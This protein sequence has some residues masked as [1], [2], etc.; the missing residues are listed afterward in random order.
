[1]TDTPTKQAEKGIWLIYDYECPLCDMYCRA[2]RIKKDIGNLTLVD[3]RQP[4]S[5]M[6]EITKLGWD[7]DN[8]MVLKVDDSLY[9]G[10]EAIHILTLLSTRTG[11]F[12]KINYFVF[13][14]HLMSKVLYPFFRSI[15][16]IVLF[17]LMGR[18]KISNL[19]KK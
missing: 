2:I 9:Y 14:S 6:D 10:S 5:V 1:M 13:K 4:S 15:R 19:E 11:L 16:N 12:N 18:A 7:I 8:G 17:K 3:A